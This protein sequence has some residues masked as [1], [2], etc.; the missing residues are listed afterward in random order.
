MAEMVITGVKELLGIGRTEKF[1]TIMGGLVRALFTSKTTMVGPFA[2]VVAL[3]AAMAVG[4]VI[5][6]K[7]KALRRQAASLPCWARRASRPISSSSA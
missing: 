2:V 3:A 7:D 6:T 4:A 1:T 5:L